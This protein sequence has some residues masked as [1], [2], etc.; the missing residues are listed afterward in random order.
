MCVHQL[1]ECFVLTGAECVHH[2]GDR[3]FS[4]N[5]VRELNLTPFREPRG[6]EVFRDV[7]C[8]VSS[9]PVDFRR[10]LPR[11]GPAAMPAHAAVSIHDNFS[12]R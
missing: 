2:H 12:S 9:T 10:I 7:T 11:K 1:G 3:L 8:G 4:A 5:C 6:D